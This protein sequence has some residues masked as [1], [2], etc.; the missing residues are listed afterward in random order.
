MPTTYDPIPA[1]TFN[2]ADFGGT[3]ASSAAQI[4]TA[5]ASAYAALKANTSAEFLKGGG[6]LVINAGTYDFGS[7]T[8]ESYMT[9]VS[10]LHNAVITGDG[11]TFVCN[12]QVGGGMPVFLGYRN[13]QNVCV[14]GIAFRD[15]GTN[16]NVNWQGAVCIRVDTTATCSKFR[17]ESISA[18]AVGA[19]WA[20]QPAANYLITHCDI[21]GYVGNSYYGVEANWTGRSSSCNLIV[22][23]VRRAF[24]AYGCQGW[25]INVQGTANGVAIG[26]N[27]FIEMV[28]DTTA[29]VDSVE[30]HAT[31]RGSWNQYIGLVHFYHQFDNITIS[32]EDLA[33]TVNMLSV[34]AAPTGGVFRFSHEDVGP[35][36]YSSTA[37][38]FARMNLELNVLTGTYTG[39]VCGLI[40]TSIAAGNSVLIHQ[41]AATRW[42]STGMP[43][44][45]TTATMRSSIVT[46]P[47][48]GASI[49]GTE[50]LHIS[51]T[52]IGAVELRVF[53]AEQTTSYGTFSLSAASSANLQ[54]DT[55]ALTNGTV[56]TRVSVFNAASGLRVE[57]ILTRRSFIIANDAS[58]PPASSS[59]SPATPFFHIF[60]CTR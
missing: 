23:N 38:V 32:C 8:A 39:A 13:P 10:S 11:A 29:I 33:A 24:I 20:C 50:A 25:K 60:A 14:H 41:N 7:H 34:S 31:L 44:Y 37:R 4:K 27:A 51:G 54:W 6:T 30:V 47:A 55:T 59:A 53:S 17:T 9:L 46:L 16:L 19:L 35:I 56:D 5:F 3:P 43:S 1:E 58:S 18:S 15:T 21:N 12:T 22:S 36:F 49:S 26:S 2:L 57:T 42:S 45:M 48:D 40:T 52:G 28:P